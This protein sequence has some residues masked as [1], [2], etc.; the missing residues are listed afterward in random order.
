[1]VDM[2]MTSKKQFRAATIRI[3]IGLI[4]IIDGKKTLP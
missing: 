2:Q 4:I 1:M 3:G